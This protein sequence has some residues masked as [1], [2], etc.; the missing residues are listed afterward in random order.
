M[1]K[2]HRIRWALIAAVSAVV[3]AASGVAAR[4]TLDAEPQAKPVPAKPPAPAPE[5]HFA[6]KVARGKYLFH[7]KGCFACH[8]QNGIGGVVNPNYIGGTVPALR[9]I[10][11][12]M[13][14][15]EPAD[16]KTI[17]KLMNEGKDLDALRSNPPIPRYNVFL[18]Q[19]HAIKQLIQNGNPAAKKDPN[20]PTPP[21]QMPSWRGKLNDEDMTDILAFLLTQYPWD[22][23]QGANT[24]QADTGSA[25]PAAAP[26]SVKAATGG[27]AAAKPEVASPQPK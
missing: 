17:V 12:R 15:F 16:A 20:G 21:L 3:L 8:G 22:G 25:A 19:Y 27:I 5:P 10:A 4:Y 23:D 6:T 24:A 7:E 13:M 14:I 18:A 9:L 11:E 2:N 26:A 1:S